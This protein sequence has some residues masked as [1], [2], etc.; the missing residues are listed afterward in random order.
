MD[1]LVVRFILV[2]SVLLALIMMGAAIAGWHEID[3]SS[4]GMITV[5]IYGAVEQEGSYTLEEG[6]RL[7][8]AVR[9]AGGLRDDARDGVDYSQRLYD[10]QDVY[11][12]FEDDEKD[13]DPSIPK[14]KININSAGIK[15]L[16]R[17]PGIGESTATEIVKFRSRYGLFNSTEELLLVD[18]IGEKTYNSILPYITV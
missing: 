8:D 10:G 14:R 16:S 1:R 18:G 9:A 13:D 17:I 11:V 6:S 12:P 15:E 4:D 2:A 3:I 7:L 5:Y